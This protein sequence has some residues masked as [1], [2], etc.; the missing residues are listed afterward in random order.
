MTCAADGKV[1]AGGDGYFF[2]SACLAAEVVDGGVFFVAAYAGKVVAD[3]G[4]DAGGEL[5]GEL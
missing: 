2:T 4:A 3:L 1:W 5:A